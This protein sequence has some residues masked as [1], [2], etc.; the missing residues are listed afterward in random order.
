MLRVLAHSSAPRQKISKISTN[1]GKRLRFFNVA[2]ASCMFRMD[3]FAGGSF[4]EKK[5]LALKLQCVLEGVAPLALATL[6]LSL[7][8]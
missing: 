7:R 5:Y 6:L 8:V 4:Q 2:E 1:D 3:L